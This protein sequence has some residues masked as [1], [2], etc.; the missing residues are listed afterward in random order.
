VI[1][2]G[3][4]EDVARLD[5]GSLAI[6]FNDGSELHLDNFDPDNP[7]SGAIE[8]IMFADGTVVTTQQLV[9]MFGFQVEGTPGE[10]ELS[11][12]ALD[13]SINAYD[14]NQRWLRMVA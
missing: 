10:D 1:E 6:V 14:G 7:G 2:N 13:D 8:Y 11:G 12:T 9:D 4:L 5:V 3:T